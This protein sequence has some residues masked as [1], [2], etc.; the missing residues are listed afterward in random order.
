MLNAA[1]KRFGKFLPAIIAALVLAGGMLVIDS[2][3]E[4]R[5]LVEADILAQD[6]AA[7]L[8]TGLRSELD[9]FSL[10]PIILAED[11]E[12]A[13]LLS[14]DNGPKRLNR[15]LEALARQ[16]NAA[17]IFLTD[18]S[19]LALAASNWNQSD[20]FLGA[21][22]GFRRYFHD[23]MANG[24]ATQF[25]LGT[26]SRRPGLYIAERVGPADAPLG[27]LTVKVEFDALEAAWRS[28]TRGVYVAD[29]DSVVLLASN[30]R[31]RFKAADKRALGGRDRDSDRRQFGIDRLEPLQI[32]GRRRDMVSAPLLDT[33]KPV[34][35][36]GWTMHL[37]VDPS[38]RVGTAV[39]NGRLVLLLLGVGIAVI[40]AAAW[41]L[42]R[43]RAAAAEAV[44][45]E[46]TR[47]LREQLSQANRLATLGQVTAGVS[48]EISQ[49]I[50]AV[51]VFAE[52]G[53]KLIETGQMA[54]AA[55][56]FSRIV[57]LT[58]RIGSITDELRRFSR[59]QPGE[60]RAMPVGEIIDGALLLLRDRI[61]QTRTDITRPPPALEAVHVRAE[62]VRL[63]QV[64]V[65]LLQN[66]LDATGTDGTI[67]ITIAPDDERL[68][69]SVR[70][71]GPGVAPEG[72]S[73]LFQPFAT[74]KPQ[75]LGL[76]LVISRDIMREL[77]GEL[78]YG[79]GGPG[80]CFSMTIPRAK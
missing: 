47:T 23:A 37:L 12:V 29:A 70:D 73:D 66:A 65:N 20:S 58:G 28:T 34:A 43:R 77:D 46:R 57:D 26:V 4:R 67:A 36:D 40:W 10:M 35:L 18:T 30:P 61:A 14:G 52:N 25:A 16:S 49:P 21:N 72:E 60:R 54:A 42:R 11:P 50:A 7:I 17:A 38:P 3:M 45:A 59:R 15:R 55:T 41:V 33:Q 13:A 6:D 78:S 31:W 80:A 68:C 19:G 76:G 63:E 39:A 53:R 62:H 24:S 8:A 5:A 56:N 69:L 2:V 27:V 9:K 71:S 75:G 74:T 51:R 22:Y 44:L 32:D 79:P 1:F 48:H 64:L